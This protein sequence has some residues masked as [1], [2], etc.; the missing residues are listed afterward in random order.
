MKTRQ[1]TS[2]SGGVFKANKCLPYLYISLSNI[3]SIRLVSF[4]WQGP[5]NVQSWIF[6]NE[7]PSVMRA[8]SWILS[9]SPND[10]W[11]LGCTEKY[12]YFP[13]ERIWI[14]QSIPRWQTWDMRTMNIKL[15]GGMKN[16]ISSRSIIGCVCVQCELTF[17][18]NYS[19]Y[20]D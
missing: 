8:Q 11:P 12:K 18:W 7:S 17:W 4:H 6:R 13:L 1:D 14:F 15:I 5:E 3:Y 19:D 9:C 2:Y 16:Y 10:L 20:F